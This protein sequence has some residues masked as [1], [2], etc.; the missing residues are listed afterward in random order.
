MTDYT[1]SSI[2]DLFPIGYELEFYYK[3]RDWEYKPKLPDLDFH[4]IVGAVK[5]VKM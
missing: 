2:I 1:R 4:R 3:Q 5:D